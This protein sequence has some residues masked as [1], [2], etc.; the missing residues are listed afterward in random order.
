MPRANA[1]LILGISPG[2]EMPSFRRGF[3]NSGLH[4]HE[5]VKGKSK[6][7]GAI[8]NFPFARQSQFLAGCRKQMLVRFKTVQLSRDI[9]GLTF[10]TEA[11]T[12][13]A[14]GLSGLLSGITGHPFVSILQNS[15][16]E[17]K[18][19]ST[20]SAYSALHKKGRSGYDSNTRLYLAINS[21]IFS[22]V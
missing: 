12:G 1:V 10:T 16:P 18:I 2:R 4:G 9:T 3:Y 20:H 5:P 15:R 19:N 21:G 11:V 17:Y 7:S 8:L 14:K 22:E 13:K 6:V